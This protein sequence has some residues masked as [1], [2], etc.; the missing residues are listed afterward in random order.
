MNPDGHCDGKPTPEAVSELASE[1]IPEVIRSMSSENLAEAIAFHRWLNTRL[2]ELRSVPL[3]FVDAE[4]P[5]G[6]V[7]QALGRCNFSHHSTG[8][9]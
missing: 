5:A 8:D 4:I 6:R 9:Q 7:Q 3:S 1:S 2:A